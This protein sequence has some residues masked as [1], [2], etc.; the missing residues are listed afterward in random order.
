MTLYNNTLELVG[1]VI[2]IS[3]LLYITI[4]KL[5]SL[6]R[7]CNPTINTTSLVLGNVVID[8]NEPV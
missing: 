3:P 7:K 2:C 5:L 6:F 1:C 8:L 4:K